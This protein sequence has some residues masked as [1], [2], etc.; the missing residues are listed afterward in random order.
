MTLTVNIYYKGEAGV[1]RSFGKEMTTTGM[2]SETRDKVDHIN[3]II[4]AS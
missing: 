1:A 3:M 2:V 4:F